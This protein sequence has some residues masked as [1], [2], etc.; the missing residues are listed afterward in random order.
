MVDE[1]AEIVQGVQAVQIV[2]EQATSGGELDTFLS[3]WY[4]SIFL[5]R[6]SGFWA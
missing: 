3:V 1:V 2:F 6:I 5:D 4:R